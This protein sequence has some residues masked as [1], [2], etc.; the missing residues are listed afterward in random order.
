M[1][2]G[3]TSSALSGASSRMLAG[4]RFERAFAIDA[5]IGG[6]VRDLQKRGARVA[7]VVQSKGPTPGCS[8]PDVGLEAIGG[9]WNMPIMEYR[10]TQSQGCRLDYRA[11]SEA[12]VWLENAMEQP[13][14]I[15]VL[16][17]FGRA[18]SEGGG[19]RKILAR[20]AELERP[21]LVPVRADYI[22]AWCEFHGGMG[23]VLPP[24]HAAIIDWYSRVA[25]QTPTQDEAR[26]S[27]STQEAV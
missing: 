8:G 23:D 25:R 20:C 22:D 6:V 5:L 13:F 11:M 24:D 26:L 12:T 9:L 3:M 21:A 7:G 2:N 27:G 14:D 16:N 19:F 17:R 10:G 1:T 18:E 4:I 15:L